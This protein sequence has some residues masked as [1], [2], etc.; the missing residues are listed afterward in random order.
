MKTGSFFERT[1]IYSEHSSGC[2]FS[3]FNLSIDNM[4]HLI[5]VNFEKDPDEFYTIFELQQARDT[6][7]Q[8]SH[9]VIAYRI[10]GSVDVY[11]QAV[12]PFGSQASI[13]NGVNFYERPMENAR[14]EI[15]ADRLE[16]FFAFE[17][18]I[19]RQIKVKVSESNRRKKKPFFLLAPVGVVSGQPASFPVYS[20]Y[21]MSFTKRKFTDIEIEIDKVKHKPDTFPLPIDC[22]KNYFT[23][24][25]ADT[26]NVD[27]NKNVQGLLFPVVPGDNNKIE[28][29]GTTYEL[30]NNQGHY[31]IRCMSI[32]NKKHQLNV[33][34]SP[35]V[36]DILCLKT[37][38]NMDGNFT[39]KTDKSTG[40]IRGGYFLKRI[41]DEVNIQLQPN[42]G[43]QPN[44]KRWILKFLFFVIK[45]FREWPKSYVW[46]A[47]ITLDRIN[48]PVIQSGWKRK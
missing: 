25:S 31:E 6:K 21:E 13:L 33:C 40:T 22:S 2:F 45:V 44:E 23:R 38:V 7:N 29:G 42:G 32:R 37:E 34:F 24:Y 26:F 20:L 19:G 36:P 48:N 5:L 43:W 16:V 18:K 3:P 35:P 10:D 41:G 15:N 4:E 12:F 11:F 14:F 46:N 8:K 39:I 27:W 47:K 28:A 17:D 1:D 9:L 30:A